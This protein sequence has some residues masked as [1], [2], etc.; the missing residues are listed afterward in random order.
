MRREEAPVVSRT[1]QRSFGLLTAALVYGLSLGG[2]FALVFAAAYGRIGRAS[3]ARTSVLLALGAFV[4]VYLVPFIKYPANPP[5]DRR[6]E[7]DRQADGAV[8]HDD[9]HLAARGARSRALPG[10]AARASLGI[11]L[12]ARGR[13][14]CTSS[15]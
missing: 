3:P 7:H 1:M 2:L 6:P 9:R 12:D 13:A 5:A 11:D 4:T 10:R 8:R 14:R 15:S